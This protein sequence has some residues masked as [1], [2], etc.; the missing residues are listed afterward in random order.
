MKNHKAIRIN[1]LGTTYELSVQDR[2]TNSKLEDAHG[3]CEIYSK[4]IVIDDI[5]E[6]PDTY[7]NLEEFRKK[8]IRHEIIH[9]FLA[10]SGLRTNSDWAE[11]EEMIDWFAIQFPKLLKI[12]EQLEL[13]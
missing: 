6:T 3:I 5:K 12:Y 1:I 2:Q 4:K 13:L 9:A 7:E 10:E 11:N 8:V